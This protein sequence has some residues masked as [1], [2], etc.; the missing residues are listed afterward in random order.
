MASFEEIKV[1]GQK[2]T[3]GTYA[4]AVS[5]T[6]DPNSRPVQ[7]IIQAANPWG[8][9]TDYNAQQVVDKTAM[10]CTLFNL[11]LTS[12][13]TEYSQVLPVSARFV[14]VSIIDG[15]AANNFRLAWTTGKVATPTAPFL[16]FFNDGTYS[17]PDK[18]FLAGATLF[19]ASSL[20]GAVAQIE[21]W[22]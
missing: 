17:T 13:N 21:V 4:P 7:R 11:T 16:K 8:F 20:A 18:V 1:T 5:Y 3:D 12:A 15:T 2:D 22:S 6:L 9:N 14:R 10:T 19:L